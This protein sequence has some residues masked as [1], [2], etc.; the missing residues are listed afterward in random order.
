MDMIF[1]C[2]TTNGYGDG[3][4]S[5][6]AHFV[7]VLDPIS[8]QI[9]KLH[10]GGVNSL[11]VAMLLSFTLFEL[12]VVSTPPITYYWTMP[13]ILDHSYFV[14]KSTSSKIAD[15]IVSEL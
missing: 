15:I 10:L 6:L 3:Q 7:T 9:C 1:F 14:G 13:L 11:Q 5:F 4:S 2:M 12:F 8:F